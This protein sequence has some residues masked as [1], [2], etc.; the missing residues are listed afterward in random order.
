MLNTDRRV[1]ED[2]CKVAN[3]SLVTVAGRPVA[4]NSSSEIIAATAS[5]KFYGLSKNDRNS[6][7]DQVY[8]EF[9]AA[10]SGK[11]GVVKDGIVTVAPPEYSTVDGVST[12]HVYDPNRLYTAGDDL[13]S[14]N[15]GL[16]TNDSSVAN[17][18]T[19]LDSTNFIGHVN[20]A[21]S[22]TDPRME[23]DLNK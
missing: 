21:P 4:L 2:S 19:S 12:L 14:N 1:L 7:V 22:A 10:G 5:T 8:G 6:F 17:G 15:Q 18:T 16:I 20:V 13:F 3:A 9:G 11:L 23:I